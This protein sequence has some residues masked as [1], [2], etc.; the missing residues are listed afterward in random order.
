MNSV[1]DVAAQEIESLRADGVELTDDDVVWLASLGERV[2]KPGNKTREAA[3]FVDGFRLSDGTVLH[4]LSLKSEKWLTLYGPCVSRDKE[5]LIVAYALANR[6]S[7]DLG[8]N[9]KTV[10]REVKQWGD[11]LA[12][13]AQELEAAVDR[14]TADDAP[15]KEGG[16]VDVEQVIGFLVAATG[17]ER[18]TWINEPWVTVDNCHRGVMK[19]AAM[20]AGGEYDPDSHSSKQALGDLAKAVMQIRRRHA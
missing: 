9:A 20:I 13:D 2:E 19:Y 12:V 16:S 8:A 3:G 15:K 18:E 10:M 17:I 7:L 5:A 1:P 4:P 6:H 11:S 14:M